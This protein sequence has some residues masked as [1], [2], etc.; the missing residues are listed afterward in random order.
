[1]EGERNAPPPADLKR[2]TNHTNETSDRLVPRLPDDVET[3]TELH[4]ANETI[5]EDNEET[6]KPAFRSGRARRTV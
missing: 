6:P 2:S 1:M 5:H 3:A 4:N